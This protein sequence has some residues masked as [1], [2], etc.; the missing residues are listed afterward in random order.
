MRLVKFI[1]AWACIA[2]CAVIVVLLREYTLVVPLALTS[3]AFSQA[4]EGI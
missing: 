2:A 1:G 4:P 3:I